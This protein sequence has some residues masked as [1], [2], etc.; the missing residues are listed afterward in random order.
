MNPGTAACWF[1]GTE[2]S[3]ARAEVESVLRTRDIAQ[4]GPFLTL[5]CPGC[6][7]RC[8]ALRNRRGQWLL[9]P[10]EGAQVPTLLDR[11]VPTTSR[12]H[13]ARARLWWLRHAADVER[14][15][16]TRTEEHPPK[17]PT[18]RPQP[19]AAKSRA[20]PPPKVSSPRPAAPSGPR[21]ILG[22]APDATPAQVR[23]AWRAAVKRWHPDRIP[24]TDPVVLM[25]ASRRFQEMRAAYEAIL[26]EKV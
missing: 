18:P 21:A 25:E 13:F 9:Y 15:R 3:G 10:L 24:T 4:G 14:F 1:C 12:E 23:S 5:S 16:S 19:R 11:I 7:T 6:R 26:A 22:C 20:A 2:I 17:E 8:G